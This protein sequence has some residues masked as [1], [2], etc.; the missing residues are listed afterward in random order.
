M[1]NRLKFPTIQTLFL[2]IFIQI[3]KAILYIA[4]LVTLFMN[5]RYLKSIIEAK[6]AV[7]AILE[8]FI[9]FVKSWR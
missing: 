9:H 2:V 7:S 4:T 1:F 3:S 5:F 6:D 8:R